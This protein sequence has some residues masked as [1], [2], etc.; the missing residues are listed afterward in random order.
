MEVK[1]HHTM[2]TY[3]R[4]GGIVPRILDLGARKRRVVNHLVGG[5]L[6]AVK[7]ELI[8]ASA[9]NQTLEPRSSIP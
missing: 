1:S 5:G 3:W 6:K 4:G 7:K 8:P 9:G 2:K